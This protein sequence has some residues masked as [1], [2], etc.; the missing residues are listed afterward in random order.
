MRQ[1]D[2]SRFAGLPDIRARGAQVTPEQVEERRRT[3][4]ADDVAEIVYTSGTTGRP[5]SCV[6]SHGNIVANTRSPQNLRICAIA[7]SCRQLGRYLG[8]S[9]LGMSE[10]GQLRAGLGMSELAS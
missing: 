8:M 2:G 10:L 9:G 6:L 5:E 3:R 4:G 7:L 1:I